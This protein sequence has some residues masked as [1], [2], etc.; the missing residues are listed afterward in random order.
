[1]SRTGRR[2]PGPGDEKIGRGRCHLSLNLSPSPSLNPNLS[3]SLTKWTPLPGLLSSPPKWPA[4]TARL[5]I[6]LTKE[7]HPASSLDRSRAKRLAP[8]PMPGPMEDVVEPRGGGGRGEE[9]GSW[10]GRP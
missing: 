2:L 1:M 5:S 8:S 7:W 6:L 10:E 4:S 3:P 9:P